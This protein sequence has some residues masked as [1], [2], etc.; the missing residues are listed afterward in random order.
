[1]FNEDD[2][3]LTIY[4]EEITYCSEN[5]NDTCNNS[6]PV[7]LKED[8]SFDNFDDAEFYVH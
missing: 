1:D 5:I 4:F 8:D 3:N 7:S 6:E 2:I